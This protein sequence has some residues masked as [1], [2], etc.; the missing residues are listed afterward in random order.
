VNTTTQPTAGIQADLKDKKVLLPGYML[1]QADGVYVNLPLFPVGGGFEKFIDRLFGDGFR[2]VGL[3]YQLLMNL[4]Y[5]YDLIL[6][7]Y[8]SDAKV[9]LA[10]DIVGFPAK[11][12]ALYRGVK[13]DANFLRAEYIFEPVEIEEEKEV[14][15]YGDAGADGVRH[16]VGTERIVELKSTILEVD[17]FIAEMWLKGIR[18]GIDVDK[19]ASAISLRQMVR[20]TFAA[21]QDA[22]NGCDAEIVEASDVLHRDN[23]PK[24]LP[25]GKADLRKFQNRFPQIEKGARLLKKKLRVQ[26]K[27]GCKVNG[28]RIEPEVSKDVDLQALAGEGTCIET[29]NGVEYIVAAKKGFLALDVTT[30]LLEVTEIMENKAGVSAKTTGDI[31]LAGKDFIEH[32]EVQEGRT[33]DGMNMTFLSDVYGSIVSKGGT[34][35]LEKNLSNGSAISFGG[36][37][38]SN[39]RAFNS[40]IE[41]IDRRAQKTTGRVTLNYAEACLVMGQTVV[42]KHAVNCEIVAEHVEIGIAEGCGIAAKFVKIDSSNAGRRREGNIAMVLPDLS[43]FEAKI[44]QVR[45]LVESCQQIVQTKEQES[46]QISTNPE[47]AKYLAMATSIKQATVKLTEA[48]EDNWRKMTSKFAKI[49]SVLARLSAEK[50]EQL[51]RVQICRQEIANLMEGR[52][53]IGKGI[54]CKIAE[55]VGDT[56]VRTISANIGINEL[57]KIKAAEL[58]I[59]LREN[60]TAQERVFF[61]DEGSVDWEFNLSVFEP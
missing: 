24:I 22:V 20:L 4:L 50:Q 19:V 13:L 2:F 61:S 59:K 11:R 8:G 10:D 45:K 30:N 43:G 46:A 1:K 52:E 49:D 15:V 40:I 51:K 3:N 25:N 48:Q 42:I 57:H 32:G 12:K 27:Q 6:D 21:Q 55:V 35:L 5:D 33:V 29:H 47:V 31:S 37:V 9:K 23:A 44:R 60:G 53:K 38:T 18:F 16:I 14:P 58:K 56:L 28:E 7:A 36:E 26:G 17:E 41:A 39:G 34:I 54:C